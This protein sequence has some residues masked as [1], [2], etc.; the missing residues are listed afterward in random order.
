ME[1]MNILLKKAQA[2]DSEAVNKILKEYTKLLDFNAQKYYLLG[3]EQEDLVQEGVLGLLK[4]IKYYDETK[5]S[6]SSFANLCIRREMITAIKR[7]NSQKNMIL[8]EAVKNNKKIEKLEYEE[9]SYE[10]DNYESLEAT[11]EEAVLLKEK[12][13][14]FKKFSVD[15]FSKF[16]KEVLNYLLRGYS[17]REIAQILTK[18]LKSIDNTIQRIRKKWKEKEELVKR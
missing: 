1:D 4:A 14:E 15:N 3:G 17:Y 2:G 5:S 13:E 16:E 6:F 18:D 10:L 11:P 7:A 12:I 8:N 9:E